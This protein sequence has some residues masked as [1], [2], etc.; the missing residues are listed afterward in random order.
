[1]KEQLLH[2][3]LKE[4]SD[5]NTMDGIKESTKANVLSAQTFLL[6]NWEVIALS[7]HPPNLFPTLWNRLG[8]DMGLHRQ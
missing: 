5:L 6:G 1:M 2:N 4:L 3:F 7:S 8:E